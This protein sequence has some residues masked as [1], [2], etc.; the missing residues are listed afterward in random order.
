M[1]FNDGNNYS[2]RMTPEA[3][4]G[5]DLRALA[6]LDALGLL[7]DVD[8]AQFDRAF[9]D[10]PAALQA[11]LRVIQAAAVADPAF[12]AAEEP[13][14]ELKLQTLTRV[15]TAVEQQESQFAPIAL[16]GRMA[17]RGSRRVARS[18]DTTDLVEKAMELAVLRKDVE[19]FTVSSYYWRAASI[20]LTAALTVALVFQLL[21]SGF[22][23]KVSEYALGN[24]SPN[25]IFD[26]LDHPGALARFERASFL[27]GL[28]SKDV[29]ATTE[30]GT[31]TLAVDTTN[32]TLM[33][34]AIGVK[35]GTYTLRHRSD[36]NVIT[37]VGTFAAVHGIWGA[38][39]KLALD[40]PCLLSS[41]TMELVDNSDGKVAM[42]S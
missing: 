40:D 27:R 36:L 5:P 29:L 18:V 17:S 13:S 21:N 24:A 1:Q 39:F 33:G 35:T 30:S 25:Q 11:E 19:R 32:G 34:I 8:A 22:A 28:S 41:G 31:L 6:V 26:S 37:N 20:A 15:M 4:R 42:S 10:S 14:A 7:D 3:G 16:I 12:L 38:E 23:L 9:R 2:D